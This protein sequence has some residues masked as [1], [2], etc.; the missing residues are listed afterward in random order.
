MILFLCN[1][2]SLSEK[3]CRQED[4]QPKAFRPARLMRGL[5]QRPKPNVGKAAERKGTLTSQEKPGASIEK[6]E[7]ESCINR[8]VSTLMPSSFLLNKT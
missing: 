6:N 5:L 1:Y 3:T 7:N 8:N 4:D 2:S